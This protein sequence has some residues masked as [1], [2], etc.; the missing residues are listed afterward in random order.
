MSFI[1]V[2]L[3]SVPPPGS[4]S[5]ARVGQQRHL[6]GVLDRRGDIPLVLRAVAGN[7]PRADLAAVGNELPQQTGVLVVHVGDLLLAE[8]ADL[9]LGLT[10]WW[11]GHRGAPVFRDPPEAG[12]VGYG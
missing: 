8:N 4:A 5:R 12:M 1:G 11:L 10:N 2:L 9:L 6:A 7:P 3:M